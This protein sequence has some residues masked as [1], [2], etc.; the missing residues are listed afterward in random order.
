MASATRCGVRTSPCRSG[1]SPS[2]VSCCL[3][4]AAYTADAS[5]PD[6]FCTASGSIANAV[7]SSFRAIPLVSLV[8]D[9][10]VLCFLQP[11]LREWR[12][13]HLWLQKPRDGQHDVLGG[14]VDTLH[15]RRIHIRGALLPLVQRPVLHGPAKRSQV[16]H[17][18]RPLIPLPA[19][20]NIEHTVVPVPVGI[21]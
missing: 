7:P 16:H 15:Q 6:P 21:V 4:S 1:F 18:A 20:R 14:R 17:V 13:A 2:S 11:E 10:V 3:T 12:R 8:L 19:P 5:S 9:E